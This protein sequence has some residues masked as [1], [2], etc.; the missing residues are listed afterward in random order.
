MTIPQSTR[1]VNGGG[2]GRAGGGGGGGGEGGGKCGRCGA[3]WRS[4]VDGLVSIIEGLR[5]R[6]E[7]L[8]DD[9]RGLSAAVHELRAGKKRPKS[10]RA[11]S[12]RPLWAWERIWQSRAPARPGRSAWGPMTSAMSSEEWE[13]AGWNM[14]R[15]M[16][17]PGSSAVRSLLADGSPVPPLETPSPAP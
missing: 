7:N 8:G 1:G 9:N 17:A 2:E 15:I 11:S 13:W 5:R 6:V 12:A 16:G 14:E 3:F 10:R 4:F